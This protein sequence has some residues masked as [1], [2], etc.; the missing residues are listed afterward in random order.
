MT[1]VHL[2]PSIPPEEQGPVLYPA[3]LTQISAQDAP[4]TSLWVCRVAHKFE[5][6][7]SNL[8]LLI[9][10]PAAWDLEQLKEWT[11]AE[12]AS[13][14]S[15]SWLQVDIKMSVEQPADL[16]GEVIPF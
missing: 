4:G 10:C 3:V 14:I 15:Y 9:E 2:Y 5:R 1:Q 13:Y 6:S 7:V 11:R 8:T 12:Y 16:L